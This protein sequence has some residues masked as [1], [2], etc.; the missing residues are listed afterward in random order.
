MSFFDAGNHRI[1][2][3]WEFHHAIIDGWSNASL[4]TELNNTYLALNENPGYVPEKLKS[5]YKEYILQ[6]MKEK[7]NPEII[8]YWKS[9]LSDYKRLNFPGSGVKTEGKSLRKNPGPEQRKKLE[10]IAGKYNTSLKHLCFAANALMLNMLSYEN[11]IVMGLVTNN[12]PLSEDGNKI[13]GCFLNSAPVRVIIPTGGA[14]SDFFIEVDK[15]MLKLKQY[16]QLPLFEIAALQGEKTGERNPLFDTLFNYIDFHAYKQ[17]KVEN[18]LEVKPGADRLDVDGFEKTNFPLNFTVDAL[19][20]GFVV[21][22]DYSTAILGD[23]EAKKLFAYFERALDLFIADPEGK[24]D[25]GALMP[26]S[27]KEE[28]LAKFNNTDALLP[29]E[30][31]I[32]GLFEEQARMMPDHCALL[33]ANSHLTY[34]ELDENANRLAHVLRRKG[35]RQDSIVGLMVER[36]LETVSG[37]LGIMKAGGAY[38]PIDPKFPAQ[39]KQFILEDSSVTALLTNIEID[40]NIVIPG[41]VERIDL[42]DHEIDRGCPGELPRTVNTDKAADLVY[43]IYTS[44]STGRPKGAMLEHINLVNLIKF[45]HRFTNIDC[46]KV[47]QFSTISFDASF[48][49]IFSTLLAGGQLYVITEETRDNIPGLFIFVSRNKIKTVFLPMAFLRVVFGEDEY[50]NM[51]PGS[52][53]HIQTAGEQ[54]VVGDKF[55]HFLKKNNVYLHNHY[56]P[57][58]THVITTLTMDPAGDIPEFPTIGKPIMNTGIYILDKG[59]HLQPI[60]VPGELY[61]GGHQVGRGYLDNPELTS[62]KFNRSYKSN[63]TY[64]L[65]RTGDLARWLPDGKI[66]FLGRIDHQVKIRGIRVEPGEIE[67]R[68]KRIEF[69]KDAVVAV[70]SD[71]KGDKYLCAYVVLDAGVEW[72]ASRVRNILS[73]GLPDYMIPAYFV[74]I[75]KIPLTPGGKVAIN[76]LPEPGIIPGNDYTAP[77]NK[78]EQILTG[79]WADTLGIEKEIIGIDANFFQVGGHSL[80][81]MILATK[82]HKELDVK[83][84]LAEIFKRPTIRAL[85]EYIGGIARERHTPVE[86]VETRE[87]YALSSAQERMYFLHQVEPGGIVYNMP[88]VVELVGAVDES[89]FENTFMKLIK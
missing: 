6:Q 23:E 72:D 89:R 16:D 67:S 36:S 33:F 78:L 66:E 44:G 42:R 85:A 24:L 47:L 37:M 30:K 46:S 57:S 77:G 21:Q 3:L 7:G 88:A 28:L 4:M 79:I 55:R 87:Y 12:R 64:I 61:A 2:L 34:K 11:D 49:E 43:V 13:I 68:L 1:I 27:E 73:V 84:T 51:F 22:L 80:K 53:T 25:K 59:K 52:V 29:G 35:I 26:P 41:S 8:N 15:K 32:H 9:E 40:R 58:E 20:D 19:M 14:W 50:I 71:V 70:K 83:V 10:N 69:I 48:H 81:A 39:R 54:V 65:Y 76:T 38:L 74:Q 31:T 82:L 18:T 17:V 75:D 63:K 5:G 86:P 62:E 60:G 45:Q 56:G